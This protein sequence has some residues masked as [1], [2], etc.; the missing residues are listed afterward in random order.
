VDEKFEAT[1]TEYKF[2][3]RENGLEEVNLSQI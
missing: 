3:N 1:K 2:I